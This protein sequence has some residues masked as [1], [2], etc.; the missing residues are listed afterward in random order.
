M[1]H[2]HILAYEKRNGQ[3]ACDGQALAA[4]LCNAF[5]LLASIRALCS[6]VISTS[7]LPLPP[8]FP[9]SLIDPFLEL[10]LTTSSPTI[11]LCKAIHK[12]AWCSYVKNLIK[13]Y[14]RVLWRGILISQC[15]YCNT[16]HTRLYI[17]ILMQW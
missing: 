15:M 17:D 4:A 6:S 3:D 13:W 1:D 14:T 5:N 12:N 10:P 9:T 7:S 2:I 11:L 16:K 8:L